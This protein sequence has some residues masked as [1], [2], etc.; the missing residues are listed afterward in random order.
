[1]I[2]VNVFMMTYTF[3]CD[4]NHIKKKF[5]EIINKNPCVK[6][7]SKIKSS[8]KRYLL[9]SR[10][11]NQSVKSKSKIYVIIEK[12]FIEI[13]NKKIRVLNHS[14]SFREQSVKIS[15]PYY[16]YFL[17]KSALHKQYFNN[18]KIELFGAP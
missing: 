13:T 6:S 11:K 4:L 5:T 2:S 1:M 8:W 3:D 17:R 10:I 7:Q 12:I 18:D 14:Q 15:V 9:K 16:E